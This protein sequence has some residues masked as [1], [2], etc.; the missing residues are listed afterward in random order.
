MAKKGASNSGSEVEQIR[1]D[2][3]ARQERIRKGTADISSLFDSQFN[4]QFY[5]GRRDAY[6]D[7]ALPQLADQS[8][9]ASKQ[10]AFSLERRGA[11]DSTS[12]ASLGAELERQRAL[13]EAE[14]KS[15]ASDYA[16]TAR[17]NVESARSDLVST[18]NA[19]GDN[20]AAVKGAQARATVLS[21]SPG[22]S[23][24][25]SLF[26]DFTNAIGQQAAAERA[27]YYGAGPRP[28]VSTGLFGTPNGAVVNS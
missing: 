2:E 12:R 11:L 18:L 25:V 10:L 7:Y 23:P 19:T 14:I 24:L 15:T 16:N 28:S 9:D 22:Y 21:Q 20:E 6:T 3:A 13:R 1:A 5:T 8:K 26:S 27:Y 4:D 17:S